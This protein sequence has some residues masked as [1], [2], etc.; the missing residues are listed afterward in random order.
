MGNSKI[1]DV[2]ETELLLL[3]QGLVILAF[4]IKKERSHLEPDKQERHTKSLVEVDRL[5]EKLEF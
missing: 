2:T 1:L 4:N 3:R 5:L